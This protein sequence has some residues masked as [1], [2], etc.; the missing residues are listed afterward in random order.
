MASQAHW[1]FKA[2]KFGRTVAL[3]GAAT[4][5][6][7]AVVTPKDQRQVASGAAQSPDQPSIAYQPD[8]RPRFAD[9]APTSA[10]FYTVSG[11]S[12]PLD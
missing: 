6:A 11:E 12:G 2:V 4:A 5:A 10:Q 3:V 1:S 8:P 9:D 7:A